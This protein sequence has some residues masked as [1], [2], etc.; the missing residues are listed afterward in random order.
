MFGEGGG[1]TVGVRDVA[2]DFEFGGDVR[3]LPVGVYDSNADLAQPAY[4]FICVFY[5][6][7]SGECVP[8]LTNIDDAHK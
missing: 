7:A 4:G 2:F 6:A 5:G 1:E 8:N 3:D